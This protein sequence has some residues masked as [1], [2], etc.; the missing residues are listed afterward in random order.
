[1]RFRQL[2]PLFSAAAGRSAGGSDAPAA[3]PRR[4]ENPTPRDDDS[5]TVAYG[6]PRQYQRRIL[7]S[8]L[9]LP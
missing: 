3:S 8:P 6:A 4:V 2:F 7:Q 9:G 1:M 5:P